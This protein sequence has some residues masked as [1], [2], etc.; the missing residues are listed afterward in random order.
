MIYRSL[1]P[2]GNSGF[3]I[4]RRHFVVTI[5]FLPPIIAILRIQF[6]ILAQIPVLLWVAC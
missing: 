6:P 3:L 2:F 4:D 5:G 1:L